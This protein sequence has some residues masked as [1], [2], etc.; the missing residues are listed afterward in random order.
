MK[1][2]SRLSKRNWQASRVK[3]KKA[4]FLF[5]VLVL[6]VLLVGG[7]TKGPNYQ[8]PTGYAAYGQPGQP[9]PYVGAGCAVEGPDAVTVID[10]SEPALAA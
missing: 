3:M 9:N 4:L 10:V 5:T 8:Y 2:S 7:C 6:A 1:H